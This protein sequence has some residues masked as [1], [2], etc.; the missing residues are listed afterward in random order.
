MTYRVEYEW[1]VEEITYHDDGETDIEDHWFSKELKNLAFS[2]DEIREDRNRLVVVR[3]EMDS[4]MDIM[5]QSWCYVDLTVNPPVLPD[6]FVDAYDRFE[7]K[8]PKYIRN[9]F[10][11]WITSQNV[12]A[13]Q[14][15]NNVND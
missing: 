5:G 13:I 4:E 7:A 1:D 11:K 10:N 8:V 15:G 12:D 14:Q 9:E 3:R 6:S 2:L